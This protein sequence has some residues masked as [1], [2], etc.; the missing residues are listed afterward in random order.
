MIKDDPNAMPFSR[1]NA[2]QGGDPEMRKLQLETRETAIDGTPMITPWQ[3][4]AIN[5]AD[6]NTSTNSRQPVRIDPKTNPAQGFV[7]HPDMPKPAN[8]ADIKVN[9]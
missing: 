8:L 5:L 3:P 9:L 2:H 4:N 7:K 1:I 6:P